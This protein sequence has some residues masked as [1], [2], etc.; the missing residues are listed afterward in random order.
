MPNTKSFRNNVHSE[1]LQQEAA[2]HF[3]S[4]ND[5]NIKSY[6]LIFL[7]T[8]SCLLKYYSYKTP[9]RGK[10]SGFML[11]KSVINP[12]K[13]RKKNEKKHILS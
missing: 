9:N 4:T 11:K 5:Q 8:V 3:N 1:R 12:S 10:L 2:F 13:K 7:T 6:R